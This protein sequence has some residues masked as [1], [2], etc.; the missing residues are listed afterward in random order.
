MRD[1]DV[2]RALHKKVLREHRTDPDTLV[3]DELGLCNGDARVDVAVING[4]IHGYEIKS[5]KDSL[6]RLPRQVKAYNATLDRVTLVVYTGHQ[7]KAEELIPDWWGIKTAIEG[8]R[9]AVYFEDIRRPRLN[10]SVDPRAISTLLWK[11]EVEEALEVRGLL[12]GFRGKPKRILYDRIASSLSITEIRTLT[13]QCL[14]D[15][16]NWRSDA[17][18]T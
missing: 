14:K 13:R 17:T 12:D 18:R 6:E 1:I 4:M 9:G 5:E 2:R 3:L 15:R 11:N 7:A 10:P 8:A 16:T